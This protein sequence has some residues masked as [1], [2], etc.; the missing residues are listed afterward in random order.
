MG[1]TSA[2][3]TALTGLQAS[4]TTIN[5]V[6]NNIANSNTVGFKESDVVFATQFLQTLSIGSAPSGSLGG[7]NP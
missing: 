1:L 2:L 6:G 4:E 3:S 5:V 7:T